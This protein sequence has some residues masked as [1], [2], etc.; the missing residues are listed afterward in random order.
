MDTDGRISYIQ[1]AFIYNDRSEVVS[2][3]IGTNIFSH[4]YDSI[5]NHVLFS[6]NL[7][8]NTFAHKFHR[9]WKASQ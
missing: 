7:T 5:G 8:T 2:A 6:D 9:Y 3:A 4:T 1:S